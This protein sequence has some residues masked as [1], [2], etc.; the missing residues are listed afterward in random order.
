MENNNGLPLLK[1]TTAYQSLRE[2]G[3]D[4]STA[5]G[6]L[7]DNSVQADAKRIDIKPK[8][9]LKN[10][11]S[12]S[13]PVPVIT[14]ISVFD[15]GDGMDEETLNGCPQLGYST[16]F[17][18]REGLGRFG[19]GATYAS[20]SQC[21]RTT[22]CSRRKGAIDYSATYIDLDEIASKSQ[23]SIPKPSILYLPKNLED[24]CLDSSNTIVVWDKCD[25]LL[26]DANGKPIVADEFL[27]ELEEWVSRAYRHKIWN[28]VEIYINGEK[29]VPHDPLYLNSKQTKFPDEDNAIERF[30]TT[31]DWPVPNSPEETSTISIKLTLLP[32]A[33]R[34]KRGDGGSSKAQKLKIDKNQGISVLRHYREVA[35]GNFHPMVPKQ[36]DI[37]RWWGCEINFQPELDECWEIRNVKRGARPTKELRDKLN[38]IITP[39][40]Q[41]LRKDVQ[42]F[43]N[44][45]VPTKIFQY[46]SCIASTLMDKNENVSVPE[47]QNS[48]QEIELSVENIKNILKELAVENKWD[49]TTD[50]THR[51]Y[52]QTQLPF[53]ES[54]RKKF[55]WYFS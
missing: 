46:V 53:S 21:K 29:V 37:D 4:F 36:I 55:F 51:K 22:F 33:W 13:E 3:F 5:I 23:I 34:M 41:K 44:T 35:Y 32:E 39:E 38:E 40:I 48:L 25:R 1:L 26:S 8:I 14:Q 45:S 28:R 43:W 30:S 31:L 49:W 42:I 54:D 18:D 47:V 7:I 16:R 15:D 2:S 19:V 24:L 50:G 52:E 10:F 6:E 9:E 11:D 17:N 20:I 27:N 12:K